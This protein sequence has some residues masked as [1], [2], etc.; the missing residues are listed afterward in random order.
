[1]KKTILL[2]ML[3]GVSIFAI[4]Q[5]P[6]NRLSFDVN[7]GFNKPMGPLTGGYLSPTLNIGH[8]DLGGRYMVNQYFGF[9]GNLGFGSFSEVKDV[10]PEFKTNYLNLSL[11]GVWNIGR[12]LSFETF[13]KRFTVLGEF[14][15]GLGSLKSE[16][17]IKSE[18]KVIPDFDPD[19]VYS[20]NSSLKGI[21]SLSKRISLQGTISMIVN[22]RQRYTFDG[23][24]FNQIGRPLLPEIPFVHA[25]ATWW[26]GTI[27]LNFYLGKNEI[28][29]DWFIEADKYATKEE[30]ASNINEI[31]DILKDSD[32][33][34]I[35]DYL[36]VEPNTP[37]GAR[38]D[39]RGATIDSDND[40]IPDHLDKC[41]FLPGP[42]STNGCPV[43]QIKEEV[44][45]FKK[46]IN[47]GY[48]NIYYAF[49]SATPLDYSSSSAGYVAN[50][51]KRNPGVSVE[52]KG[53]ADELGPEDYNIKLS[54][55]R[56]RTIYNL[57]VSSGVDASR[58]SFKGYGEDT[59]VDKA[60]ADARQ[61]ARRASFEIK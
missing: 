42:S 30:L 34:G 48:V 9:A 32:G 15:A 44:D 12:S 4:A 13:T 54:E 52:I 36:D 29:S 10:S 46:A 16:D 35:P 55:K 41:P 14:G 61:M 37:E 60:S 19:Y 11:R 26:T 39:S 47:D 7:S 58:L 6:Y 59:S 49:D 18:D 27:G 24:D 31:K 3:L 33:D 40:G 57:L 43:E 23:N 21:Y 2:V 50:F 8:V 20:F 22:G 56:A 17:R 5:K 38:V 51:M 53:Y 45:Y 28:H 25:T 1:M